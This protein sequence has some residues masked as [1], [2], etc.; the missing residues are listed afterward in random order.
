MTTTTP[1]IGKIS[2]M[3]NPRNRYAAATRI[4]ATCPVELRDAC[5][6]RALAFEVDQPKRWG[7]FGGALPVDRERIASALGVDG[8]RRRLL[9]AERALA[10]ALAG[11]GLT[12]FVECRV[13][14]CRGCEAEI[15]QP[16][17]GRP[18]EWCTSAC[19]QRHTVDRAAA[20][21]VARAR[22]A[23]LS[24]AERERRL[25]GM[26]ARWAARGPAERA[27]LARRRREQRAARRAAAA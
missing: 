24:E 9:R 8:I 3:F 20:A 5:L 11:A 25:Q 23:A 1:C 6:F 15:R 17:A 18:Q 13:A 16:R 7:V 2:V 10:K 4:C 27:E 21:R 22:W 12:P 19:M 26:R 14:Q